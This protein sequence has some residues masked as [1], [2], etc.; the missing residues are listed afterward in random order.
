M[1][2]RFMRLAAPLVVAG[3]MAGACGSDD[4]EGG[5]GETTDVTGS[6]AE[7][8]DIFEVV[9]NDPLAGTEGSGLDRGVSDDSIKVGCVYDATSHPG[10]EDGVRARV[11]R[12]N[13]E[14]GIH[15]REIELLACED[16]GGDPQQ[17]LSLVQELVEQD[18]VFGMFTLD[19]T[20]GQAAFDYL[21]ENEVPYTGWGFLPGYC[22]TRW[23]FGWNGCLAGQALA[24]AVPHAVYQTSLSDAIISAADLEGD[25]LTVAV[26]GEDAASGELAEEQYVA[27][28]EEAGGEAVYTETNMPTSGVTDY[29]PFVQAVMQAQADLVVLSLNFTNT[30]GM[31][32]GLRAAGYEG[33]VVNFTSYVP[34][35]LESS[36][37]LAD[38]LEGQYITTQVVPAEQ[39]TP[40]VTMIQD[41]LEASGA[42]NGRFVTLPGEIGYAQANLLI[43]LLDAAGEDLNTQT[44][45]QAVNGEGVTVEPGAEGGI[46]DLTYPEHHFL[47]TDCAAVVTVEDGAYTVAEEFRCYESQRLR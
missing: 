26:Q 8:E 43:G 35:L 17:N 10:F 25:G 42:E 20:M 45:D 19:A 37:Q 1:N 9:R 40:Y 16:D 14:G 3:L 46:G 21:N 7:E 39:E 44:F 29:T 22:G 15:G 33:V 47:P 36:P 24:D 27:L 32:A 6:F 2:K 13:Q 23:G 4:D 11:E 28:F 30:G 38:A 12:A 34:G 18:E 31:A 5:S 41:D